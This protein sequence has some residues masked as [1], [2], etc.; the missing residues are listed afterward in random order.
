M[1]PALRTFAVTTKRIFHVRCIFLFS[2]QLALSILG[3]WATC[4]GFLWGVCACMCEFRA[5]FYMASHT[6]VRNM[7]AIADS[8][9][10]IPISPSSSSTWP[11]SNPPSES[12]HT[13]PDTFSVLLTT[14]NDFAH[15]SISTDHLPLIRSQ[16]L[17]WSAGSKRKTQ[18]F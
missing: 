2:D 7:N 12:P 4:K 1:Q 8:S 13:L 6:G 16:F 9:L 14:L 3:P 18:P 11:C 15:H 17:Y 5:P 10:F